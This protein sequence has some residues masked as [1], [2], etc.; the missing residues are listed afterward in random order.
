MGSS[1]RERKGLGVEH[2]SCCEFRQC[3]SA[4][5]GCADKEDVRGAGHCVYSTGH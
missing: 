3:G 2:G 1:A 4:D 5:V